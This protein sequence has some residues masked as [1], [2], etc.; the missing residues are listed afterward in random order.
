MAIGEFVL[1]Y[2]KQVYTDKYNAVNRILGRLETNLGELEDLKSEMFTF[3]N[4]EAA[5][6]AGDL[7]VD[8]IQLVKNQINL[9]KSWLKTYESVTDELGRSSEFISDVASS[10]K[11]AL[12]AVGSLNGL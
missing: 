4:D 7:L 1:K 3:W 2:Q 11:S 12:E 10:A 9:T 8:Q 5:R 6:L